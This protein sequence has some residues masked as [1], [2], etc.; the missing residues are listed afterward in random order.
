MS[1]PELFW[2]VLSLGVNAIGFSILFVV[3]MRDAIYGDNW[4]PW[5]LRVQPR[6]HWCPKREAGE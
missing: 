3:L 1:D 6:R 2:E 5:C 4:C